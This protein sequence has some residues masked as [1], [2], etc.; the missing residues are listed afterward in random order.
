MADR[1]LVTPFS[2]DQPAPELLGLVPSGAWVNRTALRDG[3]T[4]QRL[5]ILH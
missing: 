3:P 4:L 2:L 1:W 5:P